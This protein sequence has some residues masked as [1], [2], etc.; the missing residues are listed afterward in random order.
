MVAHAGPTGAREVVV[1]HLDHLPGDVHLT[2]CTNIHA[3]ETWSEVRQSLAAHVPQIKAQVSP[4]KQMGLGLRLSGIAAEELGAHAALAQLR[5]F[6][7][8]H[9]LYVFTINAFPY[10]PFH[11][12]PVKE[13]VYQPDWRMPER[14][15]YS[16]RVAEILAALLPA[17]VVGSISTVPGTFKPLAAGNRV[18]RVMA[19]NITRHVAKL[20]EIEQRTGREIVLALEAEPCCYLEVVD[21]TIVFF[22]DYLHTVE[23][24]AALAALTGQHLD[25]AAVALRRHVGVC[26]DVCHG[27]LQYEEP[28][29]AFARLSEA[30]IRVAKLQLSS[31]LRVSRVGE[32]TQ[33]DLAAFNDGVYL[34]QVVQ[35]QNGTL[36]R[37]L[38]LDPA[39]AA[40]RAGEAGGEWRVHCHV[41]IFLPM[42][43][44]LESTQQTLRSALACIAL[45]FVAPH[46]EVETYTW[47]V[48]PAALRQGNRADA[49]AR[50]MKW[51]MQ[52]LQ[53]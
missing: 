30:G 50:E 23:N 16:N 28:S 4:Q 26:Y 1:M 36:T 5:R 29:D 19:D 39:F 40:L 12:R 20:V 15:D 47:D 43:G 18:P 8:D 3:G 42:A 31:A 21:E 49:I 53:A 32:T 10:G 41:P 48:L 33:T 11:G 46:L 22:R 51:V 13:D 17:G 7:S 9:G 52:E 35:E 37:Y 45:G 38:D 6:L 14:L 34:H 25:D 44:T 2:Y 27:A 24:A